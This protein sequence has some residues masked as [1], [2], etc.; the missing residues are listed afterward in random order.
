MLTRNKEE[1]ILELS[2]VRIILAIAAVIGD[3]L[4]FVITYQVILCVNG[5]YVTMHW[6]E[7]F[8]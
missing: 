2:L 4:M 5:S 7:N 6:K 8:I 3:D 1:C